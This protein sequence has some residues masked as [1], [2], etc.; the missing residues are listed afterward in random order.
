M[1]NTPE[2]S[3]ENE[4][5]FFEHLDA[6]RP[7]LVRGFAS[8]F[9]IMIV[10]FIAKRFIIDIVLMGPQ[11][12]DFITNRLLCEASHSLFGDGRLCIN[13]IKLNMVNTALGGQFNLHMQVSLVTGIALAVPYLL[14]EI[15]QFIAPALTSYERHKSRMFVLYVSLCFFTG[16]LFGYFMIAPLSINFL[17]NYQASPDI[18]NMID[19]KSYLTNILSVSIGCAVIFQLPLLIYFLTRMGIVSAAFLRHY[20]R[21]AIVLL[22]IISAIITPPDLFSLVLVVL[23]LYALYELSIFLAVRVE[24]QKAKEEAEQGYTVPTEE[25]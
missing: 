3:S 4:M 17:A 18:I 8:L 10:A 23:P 1:S 7:H 13:P 19:I 11:S 16:L 21:H 14:W 5:T 6:L 9:I 2:E 25:E 20:R 24:H 12:P 22:T 15:W